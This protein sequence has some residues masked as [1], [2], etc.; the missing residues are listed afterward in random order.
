MTQLT[1]AV[2]AALFAVV[3]VGLLVGWSF[4]PSG[5]PAPEST[6]DNAQLDDA[7]FEGDITI[8]D[9]TVVAPSQVF[10]KVWQLRNTG[11]V[12]WEGRYL[13]RMN[14]TDCSAPDMV[15]IPTTEPGES[16]RITVQVTASPTPARCKIYWKATDASRRLL[17]PDKNPIFLDVIVQEE[18]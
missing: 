17:L 4:A 13:T 5:E 16:V 9:G 11:Q 6:V 12:R 3:A 18:K 8:P 15:P 14:T 7:A 2:V 10:T 1:A